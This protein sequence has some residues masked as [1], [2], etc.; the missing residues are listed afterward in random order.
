MKPFITIN[1]HPIRMAFR[2]IRN[3]WQL[4]AIVAGIITLIHSLRP[5]L[6]IIIYTFFK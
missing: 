6:R 2:A 5:I 4:I 1:I 3:N